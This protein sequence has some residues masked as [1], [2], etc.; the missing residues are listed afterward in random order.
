MDS[1]VFMEAV[2]CI[3]WRPQ[4]ILLWSDLSFFLNGNFRFC[5]K[6]RRR[7]WPCRAHLMSGDPEAEKFYY[8]EPF[9]WYR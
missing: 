8:R 3:F 6:Y 7:D 1:N 9:G 2:S 4:H 5:V